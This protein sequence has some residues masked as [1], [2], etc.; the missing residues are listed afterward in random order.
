MIKDSELS[1]QV[2]VIE[3]DN[4]SS[5]QDSWQKIKNAVDKRYTA[6]A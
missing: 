2:A 6:P 5:P 1:K 3:Q 4:G